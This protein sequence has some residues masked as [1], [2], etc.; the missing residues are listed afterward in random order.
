V[1][2]LATLRTALATPGPRLPPPP[3]PED[4]AAVAL[5][6]A[7]AA[8]ARAVA[9]IR[10]TERADDRWSGQMA[11]P[12][13]RGDPAD[14]HPR[15]T[16]EREAREE[17]GLRLRPPH[18]LGALPDVALRRRGLA[19]HGL[20]TPYVYHVGAE[21]PPLAPD[22]AEVAGA[23]W[24][25]VAQLW[26]PGRWIIH[27]WRDADA[28]RT[29]PGIAVEGGVVWGLTYRVLELL[30]AAAGLPPLPPYER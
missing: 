29:F 3:A 5:V 12:G 13:G 10:R 23:W 18:F 26:E 19:V 21:A 25:P 27:A 1:P 17:V 4:H 2:W 15:A 7:G 20:L 16:A 8:G 11:L 30:G 24:I 14:P 28:T 6:L 22:P 9:F